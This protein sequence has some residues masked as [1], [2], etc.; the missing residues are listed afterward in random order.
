MRRYQTLVAIMLVVIMAPTSIYALQNDLFKITENAPE[1]TA[2]AYLREAPTFR[3]DG[4][5]GSVR[6]VDSWQAQTFA[7]PSFWE[8][9]VEFDCAH[10]GYGDRTGEA[11]AEVITHHSIVI[12]VTE[13]RISMAVIDGVWDELSQRF[14][15]K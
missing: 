1:A 3:F 7:Y 4:V 6:V 15:Q 12:H 11:V 9:T 5:P 2:L 10:A 8:V 14:I 13:G